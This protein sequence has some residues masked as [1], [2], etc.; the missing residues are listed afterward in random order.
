MQIFLRNSS[1]D[2]RDFRTLLKT[3]GYALKYLAK[4]DPI[5]PIEVIGMND[6]RTLCN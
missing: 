2:Y 3:M 6:T 5:T 4:E 1:G